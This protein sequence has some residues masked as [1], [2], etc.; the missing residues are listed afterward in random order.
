M[1]ES[2]ARSSSL[3]TP[4]Q[5][6]R[7]RPRSSFKQQ[8]PTP[9][10]PLTMFK[11]RFPVVSRRIELRWCSES[12]PRKA[13]TRSVPQRLSRTSARWMSSSPPRSTLTLRSPVSPRST[14]TFRRSWG[15][16]CPSTSSPSSDF[17]FF[18]WCWCSDQLPSPSSQASASCSRSL[19][20]SAQR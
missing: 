5:P 16:P 11:R 8:S 19:Q 12:S 1:R 18:S 20:H 10:C 15:K 4:P 3:S 13:P 14:S 7:K 9:S 6:L 17:R 2:T